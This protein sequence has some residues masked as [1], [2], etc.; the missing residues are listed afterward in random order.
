MAY[1]LDFQNTVILTTPNPAAFLTLRYD[2]PYDASYWVISDV[3]IEHNT[4][5]INGIDIDSSTTAKDVA[6]ELNPTIMLLIFQ[7]FT[8]KTTDF[9]TSVYIKIFDTSVFDE[10]SPVY[11]HIVNVKYRPTIIKPGRINIYSNDAPLIDNES[12]YMVL[13]TNPVIY[14]VILN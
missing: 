10:Y 14:R 4:L 11:E 13:R 8:N 6:L 12:S 3:S 1:T 7:L 5:F 2:E 9:D